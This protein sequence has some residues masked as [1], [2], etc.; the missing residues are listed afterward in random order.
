LSSAD[1]GEEIKRRWVCALLVT[2]IDTCHISFMTIT[3]N[4]DCHHSS[5]GKQTY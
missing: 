1:E 5:R 3:T 4:I 2:V